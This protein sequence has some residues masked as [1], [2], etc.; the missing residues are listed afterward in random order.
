MLDRGDE[1]LT[2]R[3]IAHFFDISPMPQGTVLPIYNSQEQ[4][5]DLLTPLRRMTQPSKP[6]APELNQYP[7]K[8][9]LKA[10]L[11]ILKQKILPAP[12]TSV[13]KFFRMKSIPILIEDPSDNLQDIVHLPPNNTFLVVVFNKGEALAVVELLENNKLRYLI[14]T[15]PKEDHQSEVTISNVAFEVNWRQVAREGQSPDRLLHLIVELKP[16]Q[17]QGSAYML[18]L[19]LSKELQ[20]ASLPDSIHVSQNR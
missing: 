4:E 7:V 12:S 8:H 6:R 16:T 20:E 11:T 17:E 1:F 2:L 14:R 10:A 5:E 3:H 18:T 15:V 13:S 9:L 19:D